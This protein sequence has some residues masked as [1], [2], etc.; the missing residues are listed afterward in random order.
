MREITVSYI[1]EML[2]QTSTWRGFIYMLTAVGIV[3]SPEQQETIVATG[4][5]IGGAV[6]VF[7]PDRVRH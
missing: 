5:A 7:L 2:S 3:L 6:G 4:L 1:L